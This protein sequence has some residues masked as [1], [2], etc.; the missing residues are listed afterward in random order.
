MK[1][2][3]PHSIK[4]FILDCGSRI[5]K[6][7][8]RLM[9]IRNTQLIVGGVACSGK[10]KF[11][12]IKT[13]FTFFEK[14][15]KKRRSYHHEVKYQYFWR[16]DHWFFSLRVVKPLKRLKHFFENQSI[17]LKIII[18]FGKW[19]LQRKFLHLS[20]NTKKIVLG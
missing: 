16:F 1:K 7:L 13:F 17:Y 20:K 2:W 3:K 18:S 8:S 15:P 12:G 10:K 14:G 19:S 9:A 4:K 5:E 11:F 6:I